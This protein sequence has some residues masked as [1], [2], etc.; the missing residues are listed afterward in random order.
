MEFLRESFQILYVRIKIK[1]L[2]LKNS[3]SRRKHILSIYNSCHRLGKVSVLYVPP[4]N[5]LPGILSNINLIYFWQDKHPEI[6]DIFL[7]LLNLS[8]YYFLCQEHEQLGTS[9]CDKRKLVYS[10]NAKWT[11]SKMEKCQ[12]PQISNLTAP[13]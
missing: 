3:F 7:F 8:I 4:K 11:Y 2:I 13:F 1:H 9:L 10:V 5:Y 12:L 6:K